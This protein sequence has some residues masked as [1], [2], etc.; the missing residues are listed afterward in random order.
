M[1][2]DSGRIVAKRGAPGA[3]CVTSHREE[4]P[5]G[6]GL[7]VRFYVGNSGERGDVEES[8]NGSKRR[9]HS[10]IGEHAHLRAIDWMNGFA[11]GRDYAKR[12]KIVQQAPTKK[13]KEAL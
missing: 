13:R 3:W 9:L 7:F 6:S 11:A 1:M 2:Q 8:I 10:I 4:G 12:P 5:P